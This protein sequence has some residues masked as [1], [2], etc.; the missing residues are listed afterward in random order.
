VLPPGRDTGRGHEAAYLTQYSNGGGVLEKR[1]EERYHE[2]P[3]KGVCTQYSM[4]LR[5]V[6]PRLAYGVGSPVSHLHRG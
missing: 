1:A 3:P 2:L 4:G 6:S 5:L